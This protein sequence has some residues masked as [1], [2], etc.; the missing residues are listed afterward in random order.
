MLPNSI[1]EG[2]SGVCRLVLHLI[3][4]DFL[5]NMKK[6]TSRVCSIAS[7]AGMAAFITPPVSGEIHGP[8]CS[9]HDGDPTS[10]MTIQWIEKVDA[11]IATNTW[12]EDTSGFGY[13]DNDDETTLLMRGRYQT[14]YIRKNFKAE[15]LHRIGH[16]Q[17]MGH[18]A[19]VAELPDGASTSESKIRFYQ[20]RDGLSVQVEI[21]GRTIDVAKIDVKDKTA[22]FEFPYSSD[23]ITGNVHLNLKRDDKGEKFEGEY[24]FT[25]TSDA[26]V[27]RGKISG[28]RPPGPHKLEGDWK[29]AIKISDD[30][31]EKL[32]AVISKEGETFKGLLPEHDRSLRGIEFKEDKNFSTSFDYETAGIKG[33]VNLTAELKDNLLDGDWKFVVNGAELYKGEWNARKVVSDEA[34]RA[35]YDLGKIAL[36]L[37][38]YY[39]DAFIAYLN[40]E[41]V[42]RSGVIDNEDGTRTIVG[43]EAEWETFEIDDKYLDLLVEGDENVFA[44]EGWNTEID[45]PDFSIHPE[46]QFRI[47]GENDPRTVIGKNQ[48]WQFLL[49]EPGD[50]WVTRE[51]S[52]TEL[53]QPPKN[54][55][56]FSIEYA[57]RGGT[58][59]KNVK[60]APRPFADTGHVI[61]MAK[62]TGLT[63][64]TGY[65]FKISGAENYHSAQVGRAF[66]FRTAA[67]R[68][69]PEGVSFVTGGDMFNKRN[70]LDEMNRQAGLQNPVFAVL[71]GDLAYADGKDP[72]RWYQW[73][74]SWHEQTVT[75][76]DYLVPMVV[77]I[78]NHEVA[79]EIKDE[80]ADKVKDYKPAEHAKFYY[81]L[82][83]EAQSSRQ[84]NY[85]IDF[86]DYLSIVL[87]DSNHTQTSESQKA[88]LEETLKARR[89]RPNLFAC[90]H[91]PAYGT[92]VKEDDKDVREHWVPLFEKYGVDC[93]F[94]ND[95]H[96][97]KR[98]LPIKEDKIDYAH[99]V[100]YMGDGSWGVDVRKIDW[101]KMQKRPYIHRG[102]DFNHLIK[103]TMTPEL[104]LYEAFHKDGRRF[105]SYP[106]LNVPAPASQASAK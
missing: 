57:P 11:E 78:G 59:S 12:F 75:Q 36:N 17:F 6:T 68:I 38:I 86:A 92:L 106:R 62:I 69:G 102:E 77:T 76:G 83:V 49:G 46:L 28:T 23:G 94:E 72:W 51:I 82:F 67:D 52:V 105:D 84:S 79:G 58:D 34:I 22:D 71:G 70:V 66:F 64:D 4:L 99:G 73:V 16:D 87:L 80:P 31:T 40:G 33:I 100:L 89:T 29:L 101:K 50:D 47:D 44:I 5:R 20:L 26:E 97:Y 37:N 7:L 2:C 104:Q 19:A 90:Y 27:A 35:P 81:S 54:L 39:D 74:D 42:V 91:R 65:Q 63:P 10:S 45:S 24:T 32:D 30:R 9:W 85:V 53:V 41:E 8:I 56:E 103:V 14:L 88:W 95:H 96:V 61:H 60:A 98:T 13:S 25:D 21:D 15:K 18:W 43:H 3:R 48:P 93:A 55:T 1:F